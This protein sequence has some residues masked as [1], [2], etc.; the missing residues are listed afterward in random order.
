MSYI[1]TC[2]NENNVTILQNNKCKKDKNIGT[3]LGFTA[4]NIV[5]GLASNFLPNL[6][7]GIGNSYNNIEET[8][9]RAT[10]EEPEVVT[11]SDE[12]VAVLTSEEKVLK[13]IDGKIIVDKESS[14]FEDLVSKY[15]SIK[16]ADPNITDE[17]MT[18]R[19]ENYVKG[20]QYRAQEYKWKQQVADIEKIIK[21]SDGYRNTPADQQDEY[22]KNMTTVILKKE[23]SADAVKLSNIAGFKMF[24]AQM[25]ESVDINSDGEANFYEILQEALAQEYQVNDGMNRNEALAKAKVFVD[26]CI[27]DTT[28]ID[29]IIKNMNDQTSEAKIVREV[30]ATID[31]YDI[32][33]DLSINYD[34]ASR[35]ALAMS[36]Y[37]T[38][39]D[40]T[41]DASDYFK[42]N[43]DLIEG[44]ANA[45]N[46]L[47]SAGDALGIKNFNLEAE[48]QEFGYIKID[49]NKGSITVSDQNIPV[50]YKD[51][52][53]YLKF[54][55]YGVLDFDSIAKLKATVAEFVGE[56]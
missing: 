24:G 3:M 36:A 37:S 54:G 17:I 55:D 11:E 8:S 22:L 16:K 18:L 56:S 27:K 40:A 35:A 30:L 2:S 9:G 10:T 52:K 46:Y 4:G 26:E 48:L 31:A 44:S 45:R 32:D 14:L 51:G 34:E 21:E 33:A 23:Y 43:A 25:V 15:E 38:E 13:L 29:T 5:M 47:N 20:Q 49:D 12:E 28:K 50:E 53:F 39:N 42:F 6:L 19:L 41:I 7:S 1:H